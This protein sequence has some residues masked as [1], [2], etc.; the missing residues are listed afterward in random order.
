[1]NS[2]I[3]AIAA[4]L[5][6]ATSAPVLAADDVTYQLAT[7]NNSG[8]TGTVTLS[9]TISGA[10]S[11]V[12]VTLKGAGDLYQP[13]HVHDGPC[14]KLGKVD[15]PLMNANDGQS[16]TILPDVPVSKLVSGTYAINVHKSPSQMALYV[17]CTDLTKK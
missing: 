9:P 12:I 2:R 7:Q 1:M 13:M 8:E 16:V 15:W 6:L 17:A 14:A 5:I 10:G 4:A 11:F 3:S